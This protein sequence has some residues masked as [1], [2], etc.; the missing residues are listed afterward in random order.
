MAIG[1]D[2][3]YTRLPGSRSTRRLRAARNGNLAMHGAR[4][5]DVAGTN[6]SVG[7]VQ[8]ACRRRA[9]GG[10]CVC[11]YVKYVCRDAVLPPARR[12]LACFA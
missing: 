10:Q 6:S 9:T 3:A 8:A 11:V 1:D 2:R 7:D 5:L 12:H 4:N